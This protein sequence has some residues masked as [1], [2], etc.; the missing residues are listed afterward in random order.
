MK[1]ASTFPMIEPVVL[2]HD[3]LSAYPH[4]NFVHSTNDFANIVKEHNVAIS[5]CNLREDIP[6]P[7]DS[8]NKMQSEGKRRLISFT[9]PLYN[10]PISKA[11]TL[12]DRKIFTCDDCSSKF[13]RKGNLKKHQEAH[14]RKANNS[15]ELAGHEIFHSV[16]SRHHKLSSLLHYMEKKCQLERRF[17][18]NRF[19]SEES[20]V[21]H[22]Q[23]EREHSSEILRISR[24]LCDVCPAQ[25]EN[26]SYLNSHLNIH[27]ERPFMCNTCFRTFARKCSLKLH[28]RKHK[29]PAR[30]TCPTCFIEFPRKIFL[31][32]HMEYHVGYEK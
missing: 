28:S 7:N 18:R 12:F 13:T 3:C 26:E 8:A 4:D 11:T 15:D 31:R 24:F 23:I 32:E 27:K 20:I 29:L 10:L 21:A 14:K 6:S 16:F 2:L 25:F 17:R 9:S 5:S 30:Y 19:L 1:D 22:V